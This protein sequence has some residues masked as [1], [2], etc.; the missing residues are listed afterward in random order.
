MYNEN[1]VTD[2]S[3]RELGGVGSGGGEE[4]SL[5]GGVGYFHPHGKIF[6]GTTAHRGF[7]FSQSR[8][9]HDKASSWF[10][11]LTFFG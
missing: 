1:N 9:I 3:G 4:S 11:P 10:V 2:K 7:R 5:Q 6:P 8:Y